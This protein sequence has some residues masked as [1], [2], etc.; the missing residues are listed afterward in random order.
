[1]AVCQARKDRVRA[2][3]I[4]FFFFICSVDVGSLKTK[5][6]SCWMWNDSR[7]QKIIKLCSI[8]GKLI[9]FFLFFDFFNHFKDLKTHLVDQSFWSEGSPAVNKKW[10]RR[11]TH[12]T[13]TK[14]DIRYTLLI[15]SCFMWDLIHLSIQWIFLTFFFS[16]LQRKC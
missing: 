6:F 15:H 12:S 1:M 5:Q 8:L 2:Y 13:F 16:P 10:N 14:W 4:A 11:V 3:L 7:K 9:I